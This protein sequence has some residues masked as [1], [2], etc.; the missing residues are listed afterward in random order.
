MQEIEAFIKTKKKKEKIRVLTKL[1]QKKLF[2]YYKNALSLLI[3]L[4]PT[5]QDMARFPHKTG[6]YLASG[7]PVISTKF[8]E[9]KNYFTDM[10]NMLLAE[11]Y[12]NQLFAEKMQF[13]IDNPEESKKIGAA[14]KE[15]AAILFDYRYKANELNEFLNKL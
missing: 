7:N 9:I 8:G 1:A 10:E 13:I 3:P 4:R 5:F 11:S 2:T 15:L 12:D 6:E 14:G